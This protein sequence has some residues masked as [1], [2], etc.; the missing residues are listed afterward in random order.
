MTFDPLYITEHF[1]DYKT[2]LRVRQC[3]GLLG[4]IF[5]VEPYLLRCYRLYFIFHLDRNWNN[6]DTYFVK[7]IHRTQQS[8]LLKIIAFSLVPW[9]V[10]IVLIFT[11]HDGNY[12]PGAEIQNSTLQGDVSQC[13]YV[14]FC[15]LEQI[16]LVWCLYLLRNV[17]DDYKMT[18][19]LSWIAVLWVIS[20]MFPIFSDTDSLL[21]IPIILRNALLMCLSAILP[22]IISYRHE[23]KFEIITLEMINS[24]ELVLQSELPLKHF[25]DFLYA[26]DF[27]YN[28][29][30]G[31]AVTAASILQLYMMCET[32]A[33]LPLDCDKSRIRNY[34]EGLGI[35][36]ENLSISELHHGLFAK[37]KHEYFPC[38]LAS[39]EFRSLKRKVTNQEIFLG[40]I[41]QTPL[42]KS[43]NVH[44][45]SS[46]QLVSFTS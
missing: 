2:V 4:H 41:L 24:L 46:Q 10:A 25:E 7:H 15:F 26:N 14:L 27:S 31:Q 36:D 20:P 11:A 13:T 22:M 16:A 23:S 44:K 40:R 9:A 1:S 33:Q 32:Y 19:E 39:K 18:K 6:E 37:L 5:L 45:F 43:I 34:A 12:L 29:T 42:N 28:K 38:F 8:W 35:T 3:L 17:F 30:N 21:L